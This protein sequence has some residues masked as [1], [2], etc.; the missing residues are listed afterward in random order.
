MPLALRNVISPTQTFTLYITRLQKWKFLNLENFI[1]LN[2]RTHTN[3]KENVSKKKIHGNK[4]T[5]NIRVQHIKVPVD[6]G[7]RHGVVLRKSDSM[8]SINELGEMHWTLEGGEDFNMSNNKE[9][10]V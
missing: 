4:N 8:L 9:Y 10:I 6:A 1:Y 3:K 2:L 7:S 5:I